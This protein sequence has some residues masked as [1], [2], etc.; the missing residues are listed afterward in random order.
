MDI[1]CGEEIYKKKYKNME[2]ILNYN[3]FKKNEMILLSESF[4]R[5]KITE[6]EFYSQFNKLNENV[7]YDMK[8]KITNWLSWLFK[9]IKTAGDKAS[10]LFK[11]GVEKIK[12]LFRVN[13]TF[14]LVS[15]TILMTIMSL[16]LKAQG[17][18]TKKDTTF[19]REVVE[20][21]GFIQTLEFKQNERQM[22]N[23][24]NK[25]AN[26]L[27][28]NDG[29]VTDGYKSTF[30]LFLQKMKELEKSEPDKYAECVKMG[31]FAVARFG[32]EH[33]HKNPAQQQEEN[34]AGVTDEYMQKYGKYINDM[35]EKY[36]ITGDYFIGVGKSSDQMTSSK[37]SLIEA[38]SEM[39]RKKDSLTSTDEDGNNRTVTNTSIIGY[40]TAQKT[41]LIS[42][43]YVTITLIYM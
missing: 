31:E 41:L 33:V 4:L 38:K 15:L 24:V 3:Q 37:K 11:A 42:N 14:A 8:E 1:I 19:T 12:P 6:H 21:L 23:E 39:G 35:I 40:K 29:I 10:V 36:N 9:N 22:F 13:K 16:N 17:E 5:N 20:V 43:T 34:I 18:E 28:K 7:F 2:K 30:K 27:L 32:Q 25:L 26:E